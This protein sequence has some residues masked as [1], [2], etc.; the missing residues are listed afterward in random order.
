MAGVMEE[1]A[2]VV[3]SGEAG[4]VRGRTVSPWKERLPEIIDGYDAKDVWNL[5]E[6]G[7]YW[8]ALPEKG[9]GEK[10]KKSKGGKK[11]KQ[12]VTLPSLLL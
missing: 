9:F 5:D 3:V 11:A 8:Q 1:K 12:R 10:G 6:T 7:C 4:E 2:Q